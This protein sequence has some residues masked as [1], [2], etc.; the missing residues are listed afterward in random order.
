MDDDFKENIDSLA[1]NIRIF[2]IKLRVDTFLSFIVTA[3]LI[4]KYA[5]LYTTQK[6]ASTS[7]YNVRNVLILNGGKLTATD[8]S[9]QVFRSRYTVTRLVDTLEKQGL[10]KRE[11]IDRDRRMK[12]VGITRKGLELVEKASADMQER[13]INIA[14]QP[15]SH[16][17]L[18]ELNTTL[19]MLKDHLVSLVK[20]DK[21]DN[22]YIV[23]K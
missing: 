10:V 21:E 12:L 18:E 11:S 9:Q 19:K 13:V 8:I 14:L 2:T 17:K 5:A 7:G 23:K 16:E 6:P 3:D 20:Q 4:R 15:L 1:D 22:Y